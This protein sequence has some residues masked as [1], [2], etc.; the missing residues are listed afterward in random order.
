MRNKM[1]EAL[2]YIITGFVAGYFVAALVVAR[3][4]GWLP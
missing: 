3:Y 1:A 2:A 4:W